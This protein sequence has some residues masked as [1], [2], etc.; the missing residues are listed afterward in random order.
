M[1]DP[2][3]GETLLQPD[4]AMQSMHSREAFHHHQTGNGN[5]KQTKRTNFYMPAPMKVHPQ[6]W[7]TVTVFRF[8]SAR[9]LAL[10]YHYLPHIHC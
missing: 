2:G 3:R 9:I 1:E 8:Y 5:I 10:I 6:I 4:K 7:L